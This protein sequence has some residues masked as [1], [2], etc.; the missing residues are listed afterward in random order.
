LLR[1]VADRVGGQ[2]TLLVNGLDSTRGETRR[3]VY[4]NSAVNSIVSKNG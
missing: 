3:V 2:V 4:P 1:D